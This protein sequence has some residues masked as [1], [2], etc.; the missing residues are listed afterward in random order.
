VIVEAVLW[1]IIVV[2]VMMTR[3]VIVYRIVMVHGGVMQLWMNAAYARGMGILINVTPVMI[4]PI[5]TASRIVLEH[6]AD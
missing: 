2:S 5:M 1:K 3:I 6:G 4:I